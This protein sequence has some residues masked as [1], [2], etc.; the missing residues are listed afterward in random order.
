MCLFKHNILWYPSACIKKQT[1]KL[2]YRQRIFLSCF[3]LQII[4]ICVFVHNANFCAI[5][6]IKMWNFLNN[7]L[8]GFSPKL[9][10]SSCK[11]IRWCFLAGMCQV[12]CMDL[13]TTQQSLSS[14][15][16]L[17][18]LCLTAPAPA[19]NICP[20]VIHLQQHC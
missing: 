5:G 8:L 9:L 20:N 11:L 6:S 3:Q 10:T 19:P 2:C 13:W 12:L 7:F 4:N 1:S 16:D 14:I 18:A 17:P 15:R